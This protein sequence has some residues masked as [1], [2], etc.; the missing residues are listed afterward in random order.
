MRNQFLFYQFSTYDMN[1]LWGDFN[2]KASRKNIFK[3][4]IGN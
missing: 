1:I 2:A 3:K 4:T